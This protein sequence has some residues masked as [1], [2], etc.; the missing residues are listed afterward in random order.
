MTND[1]KIYFATFAKN[2]LHNEKSRAKTFYSKCPSVKYVDSMEHGE[3][4]R[5]G[6]TLFDA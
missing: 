3:Q 5:I 4:Q 6:L 1:Q 2:V